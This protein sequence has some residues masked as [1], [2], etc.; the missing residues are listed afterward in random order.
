L[1][2][3]IRM[4]IVSIPAV[5][6][7]TH[8]S[9]DS[10]RQQVAVFNSTARTATVFRASAPVAKPAGKPTSGSPVRDIEEGWGEGTMD[11]MNAADEE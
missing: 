11:D 5:A 1:L 10:E 3:L 7:P 4:C 8:K 9:G 6:G 2:T